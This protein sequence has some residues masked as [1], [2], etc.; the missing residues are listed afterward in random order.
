[1][2]ARR[3]PKCFSSHP[4]SDP[5]A[6]QPRESGTPP[7]QLEKHWREWLLAAENDWCGQEKAAF[8]GRAYG[9]EMRLVNP[10]THTRAGMGASSSPMRPTSGDLSAATASRTL[11]GNWWQTGKGSGAPG[12]NFQNVKSLYSSLSSGSGQCGTSAR[13]RTW[14]VRVQEASSIV[15]WHTKQ[16]INKSAHDRAR[17]WRMWAAK[18]CEGSVRVYHGFA[19]ITEEHVKIASAEPRLMNQL[20]VWL[21]LWVDTRR[22]GAPQL[23]DHLRVRARAAAEAEFGGPRQGAQNLNRRTG[24]AARLH[25]PSGT[26]AAST[27]CRLS[28]HLL[29]TAHL[30]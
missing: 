14:R 4:K 19:M 30:V 10:G 17:G 16:A 28:M 12:E 23:R 3:K 7:S 1:M 6:S 27:S 29:A 15:N 22:S 21:P 2:F 24:F 20:A 5:G 11:Q 26:I 9:L 25:Q 8:V 13:C 18:S